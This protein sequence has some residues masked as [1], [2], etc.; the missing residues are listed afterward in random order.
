MR[1]HVEIHEKRLFSAISRP[2]TPQV[3][4]KSRKLRVA[5]P[6]NIFIVVGSFHCRNIRSTQ[7][8][9][10]SALDLAIVHT[11]KHFSY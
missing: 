2:S 4:C 5:K 10:V 6:M 8:T 9:S 7:F 11:R 3:S 1:K